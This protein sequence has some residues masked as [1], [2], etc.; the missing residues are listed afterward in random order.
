[1]VALQ[2]DFFEYLPFVLLDYATKDVLMD[3]YM[4]QEGLLRTV[5]ERSMWLWSRSR[6][7]WSR[8]REEFWMAGRQSRGYELQAL[9]ANCMVTACL[10]SSTG[11]SERCAIS[12]ARAASRSPYQARLLVANDR[13]MM[14]EG[15]KMRTDLNPLVQRTRFHRGAEEQEERQVRPTAGASKGHDQPQ[16]RRRVRIRGRGVVLSHPF[17]SS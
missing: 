13:R 7:L 16:L 3:Q 2:W 8:S 1:M 12:A 15:P 11:P 9:S 6:W 5:D 4:T 14:G 17:V 10:R